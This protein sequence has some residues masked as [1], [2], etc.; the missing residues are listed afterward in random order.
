MT[1][2]RSRAPPGLTAQS[3]VS[4]SRYV[5]PSFDSR[6]RNVSTSSRLIIASPASACGGS[7]DVPDG[8]SFT[9]SP[10]RRQY[11]L[12][13]GAHLLEKRP[14]I[15]RLH[16][17]DLLGRAGGDDQASGGA[18]LRAEVDNP[19]GRLDDVEV[20][21]DHQH[22]VAA[23]HQLVQHLEQ[24]ADVLEV[25]AGG[26]LVEDVQRAPGVALAELGGELD[27]L[28]LAAGKR[29]GALPEVDVVE[30][31]VVQ[32]PQLDG[33]ARLVLE[34][35]QRVLDGEVQH[36]ADAQPAEAHVERLAV[37]A[38]P[39]A[40]LAGHVDVG[41]EVHFD[42]HEAVALARL[43][44]PALHVEREAAG[45]VATHL[46]LGELGEEVANGR[47]ETG[48]G[49][50]VRPRRPA[51]GALV[52]VDDLVQVLQPGDAQVCTGNDARPVEVPGQDA[53]QNVGDQR[54]LTCA[55][56]AGDGGEAA[57]RHVDGDV[58]QVVLARPLDAEHP[59]W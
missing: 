35:R 30:A 27:T 15:R 53:M 12:S 38:L 10:R 37:V 43:T 46:G 7:Y 57:E 48:V 24:H 16:F 11:R 28:R 36:L 56:H 58:L 47:E 14:R 8:E 59:P 49:G 52:D 33:D 39:L 6:S 9:R 41:K 50:R 32:G 22:R 40:R 17:H 13:S 26:R 21:L 18:A 42:L 44:A 2:L 1:T 20:V 25:Q 45:T 23:V 55:G 54:A 5:A 34:E 31:D 51:D 29:G 4:I 3:P 19:V